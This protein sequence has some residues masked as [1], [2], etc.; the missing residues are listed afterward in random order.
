GAGGM[1]VVFRAE[2]IKHGRPVAIKI[3]KPELACSLWSGR[4]L[5]EIQIASRLQHPHIL[6]LYDSG[7]VG[8]LLYYVMPFVTG[9]SLRARL[10]REGPLSIAEAVRLA[11]EVA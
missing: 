7:A 4:F 8:D 10:S 1:A 2:D 5:R 6:P 11:R 3:L 9:E